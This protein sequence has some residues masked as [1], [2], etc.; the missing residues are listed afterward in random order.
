[1]NFHAG[2]RLIGPGMVFAATSIGVS[3]VVQATRAGA[4]FGYTLA[5]L[6]IIAHLVK[7][8]FFRVGAV[9]A[10]I[11]GES[12]LDAYHRQGKLAY[13]IA[14][15]VNF[16]TMFIIMAAVSIVAAGVLANIL[17]FNLSVNLWSAIVMFS[18]IGLLVGGGYAL[19]NKLIRWMMLVFA[20]LCLVTF[21]ALFVVDLPSPA[22][23]QVDY[24]TATSIAFMVALVG[25]MPTAIEVS[26]WHSLWVVE[27]NR[28]ESADVH[29]PSKSAAPLKDSKLRQVSKV[30]LDFN[31]GYIFCVVFALMFMVFGA[32]LFFGQGQALQDSAIGFSAQLITI[33]TTVLGDWS[34]PL[35]SVLIFI[36]MYS[37]CLAVA[38]GFSQVI[39]RIAEKQF[40]LPQQKHLLCYKS[41]IPM[42]C[43]GGWLVIYLFAGQ[44]KLLIDFATTIAFVTAPVFA[45]LNLRA[46]SLPNVP[47]EMRIKGAYR[48]YSWCCLLLLIGFAGFF[49]YWFLF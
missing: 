42:I 26:V 35:V 27:K 19:L 14:V 29:H 3:H 18:V 32:K 23:V 45:W 37:T 15:L 40:S 2:L 44:L 20:I 43:L 21:V 49:V 39:T 46:M 8:P 47:I 41:I 38:D 12:L 6:I 10:A 25:W 28:L 24:S 16:V 1:M 36:A 13:G 30:I 11:T 5:A 7:L 34:R 17:P 48:L 31:I 4:D 22:S 33:F 9:Y